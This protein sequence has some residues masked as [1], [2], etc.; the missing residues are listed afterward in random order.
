MVINKNIRL[1]N[2]YIINNILY[3]L[4]QILMA[5]NEDYGITHKPYSRKLYNE[6]IKQ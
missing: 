6:H 2:G 1:T 3:A 5:A 4:D